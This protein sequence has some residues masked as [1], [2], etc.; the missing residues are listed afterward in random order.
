M[1]SN[2]RKKTVK[3]MKTF[4]YIIILLS[5]QLFETRV[6]QAFAQNELMMTQE[7]ATAGTDGIQSRWNTITSHNGTIYYVYVDQQARTKVG[8]YRNGTWKWTVVRENTILDAA[9]NGP[10]IGIDDKGFI[11]T[12]YDMHN[13]KWNYSISANP[14]DISS[15]IKTTPNGTPPNQ[16][17]SSGGVS[18]AMFF[19][20]RLGRLWLTWR[21]SVPKTG[22]GELTDN[23]GQTTRS[24]MLA[25]Y[26]SQSKRWQVFGAGPNQAFCED[27]SYGV[28]KPR[29]AFDSNNRIHAIWSWRYKKG[30]GGSVTNITYA[31]SD[32]DGSIWRRIDG[33]PYSLPI[34]QKQADDGGLIHRYNWQS[35]SISTNE[36][37][38]G[39]DLQEKPLIVYATGERQIVRWTGTTWTDPKN[40]PNLASPIV[41][42]GNGELVMLK[43]GRNVYRSSDN[44]NT[45]KTYTYPTGESFERVVVDQKYLYETGNIRF[46][47]H[48]WDFKGRNVVTLLFTNNNNEDRTPP[49][50]PVSIRVNSK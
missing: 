29:L 47:A 49:L 43:E 13:N 16:G 26:D 39:L 37:F 21:A 20:D 17:G 27:N 14:E 44:G 34:D 40:I 7:L 15:M 35:Y 50:P 6:N 32:D 42:G 12:T 5:M 25:R 22:P 24:G 11:H 45:W 33:R 18:Y 31:Y 10:S 2:L 28:Y 1:K 9:H 8:M 4:F 41:S 23:N 19:Q 30:T 46:G 48:D 38:L 36:S 3:F